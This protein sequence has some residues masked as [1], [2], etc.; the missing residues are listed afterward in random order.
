[1][2]PSSYDTTL[3][4]A[5]QDLEAAIQERDRWNLEVGRL[6]QLVTALS[7]AVGVLQALPL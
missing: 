5:A 2:T 4:K 7:A 6:N 3:K 1:M